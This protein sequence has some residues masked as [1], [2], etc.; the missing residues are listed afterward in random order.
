MDGEKV[1][2]TIKREFW[3]E[4]QDWYRPVSENEVSLC[5]WWSPRSRGVDIGKEGGDEHLYWQ[6]T[7]FHS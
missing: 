4:L 5:P 1:L 7:H 3:K 2:P 6:L